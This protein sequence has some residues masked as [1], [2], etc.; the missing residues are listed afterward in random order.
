MN[1]FTEN[2][3]SSLSNRF[4]PNKWMKLESP[5]NYRIYAWEAVGHSEGI[6]RRT[7]ITNPW[8]TTQGPSCQTSYLN[9]GST[10]LLPSDQIPSGTKYSESACRSSLFF[11]RWSVP[12]LS[13]WVCRCTR[14]GP[15]VRWCST[16]K[17]YYLTQSPDPI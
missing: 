12:F 16:F 2:S 11:Q 7:V 6:A 5:R 1:H 9:P 17:N 3:T 4:W 14:P 15:S 13:T 8:E 10:N